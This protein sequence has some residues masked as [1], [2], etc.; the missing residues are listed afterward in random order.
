AVPDVL[1]EDAAPPDDFAVAL[2]DLWDE[3]ALALADQ[4]ATLVADA[5]SWDACAFAAAGAALSA[6]AAWSAAGAAW[7]EA[8][9]FDAAA[10]LLPFPLPR[11]F[12]LPLPF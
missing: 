7:S 9:A 3:P 5:W 6:V 2:L 12:A 4:V 8:A 10:E 1:C 11:P